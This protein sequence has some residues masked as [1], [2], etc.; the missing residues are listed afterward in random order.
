M[1]NHEARSCRCCFA[2]LHERLLCNAGEFACGWDRIPVSETQESGVDC[3]SAHSGSIYNDKLSYF[4]SRLFGFLY[5]LDKL[6]LSG[7]ASMSGPVC[8]RLLLSHGDL[9]NRINVCSFKK[10]PSNCPS[11]ILNTPIGAQP[12]FPSFTILVSTFVFCDD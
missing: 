10:L 7:V 12:H 9:A 5:P 8:I 6:S 1:Y 3:S 2:A 11:C 4:F